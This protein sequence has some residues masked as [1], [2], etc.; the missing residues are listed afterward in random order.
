MKKRN[1]IIF[2]FSIIFALIMVLV[3]LDKCSFID[4]GIYN[5]II[6]NRCDALDNYFKFITRLGNY[7]TVIAIVLVLA[8]IFH[9]RYSFYLGINVSSSVL[10]N[11][12]FKQCI[13]RDRPNLL[14]LIEQGGYSFP[15][16]H[17]MISI[18]LYGYLFYLTYTKVNN[19]FLK[20]S[21]SILLFLI[22]ISIGVSRIY[23]GVHYASDVIAGYLLATIYVM[24]FIVIV[25]KFESRGR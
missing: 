9:N 15:S 13:R 3:I 24:L 8:I 1:L 23:L 6:S 22:I 4:N 19:K 25:E 17:A 11:T 2:L 7:K 21:V 10:L 20:Y 14:R 16:G 5:F 18:C 12:F